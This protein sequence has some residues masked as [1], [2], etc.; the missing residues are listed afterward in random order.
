[1]ETLRLQN[2]FHHILIWIQLHSI[3]SLHLPITASLRAA[4]TKMYKG[5]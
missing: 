3:N 1:M 4:E 5:R 2:Y